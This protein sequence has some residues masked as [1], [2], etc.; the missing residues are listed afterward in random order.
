[1]SEFFKRFAPYFKDYV[2]RFVQAAIGV[3][4]VAATDRRHRPT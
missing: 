4:M 3:V 1:M 2:P